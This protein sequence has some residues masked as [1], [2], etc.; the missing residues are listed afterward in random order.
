MTPQD[1]KKWR[2]DS[3]LT[4]KELADLIPLTWGALSH[5]ETGKR[6]IPQIFLRRLESI[7]KDFKASE[8]LKLDMENLM[9]QK[10]QRK[11]C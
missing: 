10:K 4:L 1:L 6:P 2:L 8:K 3:G 5:Y 9:T 11:I 7:E